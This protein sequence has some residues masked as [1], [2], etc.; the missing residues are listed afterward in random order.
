MT[1]K[2][3]IAMLLSPEAGD[4]M[5]TIIVDTNDEVVEFNTYKAAEKAVAKVFSKGIVKEPLT[6]LTIYKP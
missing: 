6:I 1:K 2:Y 3:V 5:Q 4:P